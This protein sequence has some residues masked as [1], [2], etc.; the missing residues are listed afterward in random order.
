MRGYRLDAARTAEVM[1]ADGTLA[2]GDVGTLD[3]R[4]TGAG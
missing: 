4:R 2:T 1:R 3:D